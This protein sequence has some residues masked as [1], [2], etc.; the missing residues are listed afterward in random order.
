MIPCYIAGP[1]RAETPELI[2]AN[3]DRAGELGRYAVECGRVPIVPHLYGVAVYGD[4]ETAL[5][6]GIAL[7]RMVRHIGGELWAIKRDNGSLSSG[8]QGE[9][10]AFAQTSGIGDWDD[11]VASWPW[12]VWQAFIAQGPTARLRGVQ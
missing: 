11:K 7:V 6:Q 8:V 1:Y 12:A 2:Q 9:F 4:D 10:E 5:A 3:I